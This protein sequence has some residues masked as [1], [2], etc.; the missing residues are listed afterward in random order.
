M[1]ESYG[2]WIDA[3]NFVIPADEYP[4]PPYEAWE[5]LKPGQATWLE[6][7]ERIDPFSSSVVTEPCVSLL[8]RDVRSEAH[9][10]TPLI[11]KQVGTYFRVFRLWKGPVRK[12]SDWRQ[13]P[14][15]SSMLLSLD[16]SE[17]EEDI[18]VFRQRYLAMQGCGNFTVETRDD[19]SLWVS[20]DQASS[21]AS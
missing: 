17:K 7:R 1:T 5:H 2:H 15:G 12:L 3:N 10:A 19:G 18:A 8:K 13:L 11:G 21:L 4:I 14:V 16:E 20:K 9:G 6:I